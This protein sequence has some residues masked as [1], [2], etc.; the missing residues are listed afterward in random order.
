MKRLVKNTANHSSKILSF[1][2]KK[3]KEIPL[4]VQSVGI[5]ET[6]KLFVKPVCLN[7]LKM[8]HFVV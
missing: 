8:N 7:G 3:R 2:K 1:I 4:I 6:W 5:A